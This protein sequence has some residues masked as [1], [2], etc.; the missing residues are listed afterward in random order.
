MIDLHIHTNNSDGS[1]SVIDVLKKAQK[2]ELS[3]MSITETPF[4]FIV[5]AIIIGGC[6]NGNS[7]KDG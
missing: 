5:F 4:P 1:D 6:R 2:H 3:Y 7:I